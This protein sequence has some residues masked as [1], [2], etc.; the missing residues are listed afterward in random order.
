[1]NLLRQDNVVSDAARREDRTLQAL[2]VDP[3]SLGAIVPAYLWR[4]R[5]TGQF[6]IA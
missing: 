2:G 6:K 5:K 3:V 1:V 4:F